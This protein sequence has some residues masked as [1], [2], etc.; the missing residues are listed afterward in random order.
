MS[1]D[2]CEV[3]TGRV[4]KAEN[5][6]S[7][8]SAVTKCSNGNKAEEETNKQRV[9]SVIL[10]LSS[11][12]QH[13]DCVWVFFLRICNCQEM[14][15]GQSGQKNLVQL[16]EIRIVF[17]LDLLLHYINYIIYVSF[18]LEINNLST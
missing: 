4:K 2:G 6:S 3:E 7:L 9:P 14:G 17:H 5:S 13:Q 1:W 11:C 15:G 16:G 12:Y 8:M 10:L 18:F